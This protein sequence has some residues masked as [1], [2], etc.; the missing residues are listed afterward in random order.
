M[1]LHLNVLWVLLIRRVLVLLFLVGLLL[2][3]AHAQS[4][5]LSLLDSTGAIQGRVV[6]D[7]GKPVSG[8]RVVA[9]PL[10]PGGGLMP[11]TRTD[12]RGRFLFHGLSKKE[13]GLYAF[14]EKKASRLIFAHHF[15]N[16]PR[17]VRV[18]VQDHETIKDVEL[19]LLP[20]QARVLGQF[21]NA[22]TGRP[23]E[24]GQLRLCHF[25]LV[26]CTKGGCDECVFLPANRPQGAFW[27]LAPANISLTLRVSVPGYEDWYYRNG[28]KQL[29]PLVLA[30]GEL[31]RLE[32]TLRPLKTTK[33]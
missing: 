23:V 32:I 4:S 8:A 11:M 6:N 20:R 33:N 31:K 17:V 22:D 19:Q 25:G 29:E 15:S 2:A 18:T 3:N 27:H 1:R 24:T 14:K 9:M 26:S 10:G 5:R 21:V 16:D 13:Y 30:P 7:Q 28:S 12:K